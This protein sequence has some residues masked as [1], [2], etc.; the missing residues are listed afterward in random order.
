MFISRNIRIVL[1]HIFFHTLISR[2]SEVRHVQLGEVR[3]NSFLA[4]RTSR[5]SRRHVTNVQLTSHNNS[6]LG[7]FNV[8]ME[9][10][11]PQLN[12][13]SNYF[14]SCKFAVFY[15]DSVT[16]LVTLSG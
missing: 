16:K 13:I 10:T 5:P 14:S 4:T 7:A 2:P 12:R 6:L 8:V 9:L 3:E 11:H 15:F 1:I